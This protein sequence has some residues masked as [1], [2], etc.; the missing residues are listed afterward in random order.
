MTIKQLNKLRGLLSWITYYWFP[1]V[2]NRV[3]I[4]NT[5]IDQVGEWQLRSG[6]LWTIQRIKD[7][8]L[9]YTRFI[10]GEPFKVF[11]GRIGLNAKGLPKA[12]PYFN[13][14]VESGDRRSI[15]FVLTHLSVSRA[16]PGTKDPSTA[17]ITDASTKDNEIISEL[18]ALIP[19][20]FKE[21]GIRGGN[22]IFWE[23]S[24]IRLTNKAG[25][26]GRATLFSWRDAVVVPISIIENITEMSPEL[27]NYILQLRNSWPVAIVKKAHQRLKHNFKTF[28]DSLNKRSLAM[29]AKDVWAPVSMVGYDDTVSLYNSKFQDSE[30]IRKLSIIEDPEAKARVIAIFDFWSQEALKAV[31]DLEF[32]I[33]RDNLSQDRTFTQDPIISNKQ[34]TESFHSIDL[35]AATDRFP[36]EIQENVV[37]AL[38]NRPFARA[39]KSLLVDHEFYVPWNGSTVKYNAGQPMGAYSS[40]STFAISHHLVVFAAAKLVGISNFKEYILL[41][42]DIVIYNDRVAEQYKLLMKRLGVDTSPHKT[43]T[44]K[45]TYEFAKRWFM[46]GKE[47]TGIQVRGLLDSMGKYHLI[48]QMVYTLYERGQ[49]AM[50]PVTIP[51]LI[52]SLYTRTGTY[53]RMRKHLKYKLQMIHA[54]R[55]YIVTNNPQKILAVIKQR[56]TGDYELPQY[57]DKEL[58]NFILTNIYQ[59]ASKLIQKGTAEALNYNTGLFTGAYFNKFAEA[60]ANPQ[61]LWTSPTYLIIKSPLAQAITNRLKILAESLRVIENG[62]VKDMIQVISLPDPASL[63]QRQSERIIS[64]EAALASRFFDQ[65]EEHTKGR[66]PFYQENLSSTVAHKA[67]TDM[68]QRILNVDQYLTHGLI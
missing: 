14:L 13:E 68:N 26:E 61:D 6:Q 54:F 3:D 23:P 28:W 57:N 11:P 2:A 34:D 49:I 43:H 25:P 33:L 64:A 45:T 56:Y 59:S 35:T 9:I 66:P 60:L 1:N 41:G 63:E 47:I 48:Y 65:I 51:D 58:D 7:L 4:T 31:H 32:K 18:T 38:F 22:Q 46:E 55:T 29:K 27:G 19:E 53:A 42:D 67:Y 52:L 62:S 30:R 21:N 12:L 5:W 44:S 39:W 37:E 10:S 24:K 17:T 20:F 8:R 36:I 50:V 40:W 15:S 16:I